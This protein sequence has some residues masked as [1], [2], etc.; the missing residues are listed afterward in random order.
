M[1]VFEIF[2]LVLALF[3]T[4]RLGVY[5]VGQIGWLGVLPAVVLGFGFVGGLLVAV[6]KLFGRRA[7][8]TPPK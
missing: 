4:F 8:E 2:L 3:L 6:R 7:P 1:N 5:F